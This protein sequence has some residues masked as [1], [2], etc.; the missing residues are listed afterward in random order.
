M[1]R[2]LGSILFLIACAIQPY[3]HSS[4]MLANAHRISGQ[5]VGNYGCFQGKIGVTLTLVGKKNGTVEGNFLFYP[6][7]SN[8]QT[9]SGR[10]VV[11][12]LYYFDGFLI[13]D[14]GTWVEKPEGY[15]TVSLRG[16]VNP[17]FDTFTGTVPECFNA[18]FS[19]HRAAGMHYDKTLN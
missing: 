11:T 8:P 19:L 7:S 4:D 1:K 15:I 12:G 16:K 18:E 9:A 17:A 6:L 2:I 13:L 10:F 5:W 14:S 3:A